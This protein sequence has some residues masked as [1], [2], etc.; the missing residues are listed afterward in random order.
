M[1]SFTHAAF[2]FALAGLAL[3]VI[4][5]RISRARP[6]PWRFPSI[7]RIP[8]NP[9]PR[10]GRRKVSDWLLMLMRMAFLALIIFALS[11]PI[12]TPAASDAEDDAGR[13]VTFIVIDW[14]ASMS[15]W[16]AAADA[17]DAV[18][19]VFAGISGSARI[20]WLAFA[21][22]V[23]QIQAPT[24]ELT[25]AEVHA[26]I[27][28]FMRQTPPRA[29]AASPSD[30]LQ[31]ALAQIA[32]PEGSRMVII[33]DFQRTA[34]DSDLPRISSSIELELVP[35][36]RSNRAHNVAVLSAT[37]LPVADE[38]ISVLVD[39]MNFGS[40]P[41]AGTVQV[42]IAGQRLQQQQTFAA[43]TRT[44]VAFDMPRTGSQAIGTARVMVDNDPYPLDDS[45][46]FWAA[47]PPPMNLL[48][49][50]P[51]DAQPLDGE[52]VFFLDQAL[53]AASAH[54]WLR[55]SVIPAAAHTLNPQTL[56]RS[57]GVFVPAHAASAESTPFDRLFAYANEGGLVIVSLGDDAVR[58]MQR[59]SRA[60]F[61]AG[62]YS[63]MAARSRDLRQ[64]FFVG[65]IPA[66]SALA[67]VFSGNAARDLFLLTINQHAIIQPPEDAMPLLLSE[68]GH[69]L[70][71]MIPVGKGH[72]ILSTFPWHTNASDLPLRSSFLPLVRELLAQG[73]NLEA[74]LLRLYT[75]QPFPDLPQF[76]GPAP[77]TN[78][79]RAF[80][81]EGIP[82]EINVTRAESDPAVL[83]PSALE[84][85]LR[86]SSTATLTAARQAPQGPEDVQIAIAPWLLLAAFLLFMAES[87]LASRVQS[88]PA[89]T[90]T[91]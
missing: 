8:S 77:A 39:V 53:A 7:A 58:A 25:V 79:P 55:F 9:L 70:L 71:F 42:E 37:A 1:L 43:Q 11:G 3:P 38:R 16:N 49:Y 17:A 83:A 18:D 15:G 44:A 6:L 5:H 33:S 90:S 78:Q 27:R 84:Q 69:P 73:A 34:W 19:A 46:Q 24:S 65:E 54:E 36:G 26:D 45:Y 60:G 87:L 2:L 21:N 41:L 76:S 14:S 86:G 67:D 12:W 81:H 22:D 64:R 85:R 4:I 10:Q 72:L 51:I 82:V 35:V 74:A 68:D 91:H 63:A 40:E 32:Q 57:A 52:E 30:A 80:L 89:A 28:A 61:N 47:P 88:Q 23:L 48:A 50:L 75:Y 62:T 66:S 59:L 56:A 20:G 13:G 29:A 31:L